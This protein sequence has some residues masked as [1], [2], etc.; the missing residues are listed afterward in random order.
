MSAARRRP[1]AFTLVELLV[2]IAIIG[3]LVGLLVPAVQSAREAARRMSCSNQVKQLGLSLH[4]YHAAY[5]Q[6]PMHGTGPTNERSR[7]TSAA[8]NNNGTGFTRLELS[9]LVGLLPFLEQQSLWQQISNPMIES[10]GDRWPAFGPRPLVLKYPPWLTEIPTLRC[11]S[12]PGIGLPALGRTNYAACTG[13]SFYDAENGATVWTG[14]S[15]GGRWLY[16]SDRHAMNRVRCGMRGMFVPRYS[17][18][19]RDCLDGLSNTIALGEVMTGLSDG[20]NRT[21]GTS[22]PSKAS[23]G[24]SAAQSVADN[25]NQCRDLGFFAP[26]RPGD[27]IRSGFAAWFPLGRLPYAAV[28]VQ[29]DSRT[30][31]AS[32]FSR[33]LRYLRCRPT[34]QPSSW[35]RACADG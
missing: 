19:F 8:D 15:T 21:I 5:R 30:E 31:L 13:D 17:T 3:V 10:D 20:S 2:V 14:P 29:Y 33:K 25:P 22:A 9:Y 35:R 1:D 34:E 11:P 27:D 24:K 23:G 16:Q 4:N 26:N 18:R 32:L 28:A 6:L 12:D 7:L